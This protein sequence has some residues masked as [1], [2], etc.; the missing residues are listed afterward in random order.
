MLMRLSCLLNKEVYLHKSLEISNL[1]PDT[2][3]ECNMSTGA[4]VLFCDN[5][6]M[7][8]SKQKIK[9]FT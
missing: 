8:I 5:E 4:S 3:V 1:L 9:V 6:L 7:F 2:K